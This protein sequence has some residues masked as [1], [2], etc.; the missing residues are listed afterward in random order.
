MQIDI[1][2]KSIDDVAD[3]RAKAEAVAGPDDTITIIVAAP[4]APLP[5]A[6]QQRK[7]A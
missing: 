6:T 1:N 2:V 7:Q 3:A 5:A 4:V